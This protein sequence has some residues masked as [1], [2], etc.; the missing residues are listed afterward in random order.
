M[1]VSTTGIEIFLT[2]FGLL[3]QVQSQEVE[4]SRVSLLLVPPSC[5]FITPKDGARRQLRLLPQPSLHH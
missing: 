3:N 4:E 1:A 5:R 2:T